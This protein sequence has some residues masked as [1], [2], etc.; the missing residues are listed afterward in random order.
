M[1]VLLI[2]VA[3]KTTVTTLEVDT[4]VPAKLGNFSNPMGKIVQ[5]HN[6][7]S[8]MLEFHVSILVGFCQ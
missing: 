3:A 4:D 1:N 8:I 2:M 7:V 5:T 6:P